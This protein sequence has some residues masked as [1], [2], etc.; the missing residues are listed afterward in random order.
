MESGAE[1]DQ[2]LPDGIRFHYVE[3]CR[4]RQLCRAM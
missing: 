2:M 3:R 1:A 4:C